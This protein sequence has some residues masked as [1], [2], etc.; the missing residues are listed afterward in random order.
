[1]LLPVPVGEAEREEEAL[2]LGLPGGVFEGLAPLE[3]EAE[4]G[5]LWLLLL[6]PEAEG[7]PVPVPLTVML[8]LGVWLA[9]PVPL[10]EL[11][12]LAPLLREAGAEGLWLELRLLLLL[13]D[14]VPVPLPVGV[15]ELL[16]VPVGELLALL[17]ALELAL[18]VPLLEAEL[19]GLAPRVREAVL[20]ALTVLLALRVEEGVGAAV[21]VPLLLPVC[22][23]EGVCEA[24]GVAL[25]E[26][27]ME[28]LT[29]ALA[30][31]DRDAV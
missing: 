9:L 4:G 27:D 2:L 14:R 5:V 28:G 23:G 1:M 15:P 22:V 6:L 20:L 29:E 21:P 7:V 17:L 18:P 3:R 31:A 13:G 24:G 25:E 26:R 11:L 12:G 16:L 30:P 19:L 10:E 8:W